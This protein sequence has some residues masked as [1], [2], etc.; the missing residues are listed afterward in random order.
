MV[1]TASGPVGQLVTKPVVMV[2]KPENE[3]AQTLDR[4]MVAVIVEV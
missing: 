1:G 2:N 4:P 3:P